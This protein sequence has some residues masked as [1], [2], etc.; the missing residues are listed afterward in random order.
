MWHLIYVGK[1]LTRNKLKY[2]KLSMF[3]QLWSTQ[4]TI[5]YASD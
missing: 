5:S 4:K 2:T 3:D 1:A